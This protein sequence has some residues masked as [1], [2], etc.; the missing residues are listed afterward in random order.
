MKIGLIAD[1]HGNFPALK[2]ILDKFE[3]EECDSIYCLGDTIAIGPSSKECIDLLLTLPNIN[4]IMGNHEEYFVKGVSNITSES[5]SEGEKQ[6]QIWTANSLNDEI[7][8]RLSKF[9]YLIEENIRGTNVA[10]M[11][12]ALNN[13]ED[14]KTFKPIEKNVTKE[15]MNTLFKEVAS[16]LIFF[17]HEHNASN[18]IGEKHYINIG[19]SGCTKDDITHCTIVKFKDKSYDIKVHSMK[20]DK[21]DVLRE[22][23]KRQVPEKESISKYFF[24]V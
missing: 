22:L 7:R 5:M 24:N 21:E 16:D 12:Y 18:I 9:P 17:G 2:V 10:F 8:E 13:R 20:Y 19:S 3:S 4:F 14:T 15:T 6:H 1:I 23:Y 11:H